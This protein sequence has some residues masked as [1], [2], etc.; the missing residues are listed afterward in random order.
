L[1]TCRGTT[2]R[3][4]RLDFTTWECI[5]CE[6]QV[7]LPRGARPVTMLWTPGGGHLERVIFFGGRAVHRCTPADDESRHHAHES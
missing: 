3:V 1:I 2:A 4:R 5:S 6:T 7:E